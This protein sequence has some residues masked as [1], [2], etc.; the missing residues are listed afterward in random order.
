MPQ[1]APMWWE[2]LFLTFSLM[3]IMMVMMMYHY[4]TNKKLHLKKMKNIKQPNW[5]W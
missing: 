2:L 5:K 3:M 4:P 1:M